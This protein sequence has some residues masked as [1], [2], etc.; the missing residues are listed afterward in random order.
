MEV[1]L[2]LASF[3]P[4]FDLDVPVLSDGSPRRYSFVLLHPSLLLLSLLLPPTTLEFLS[5][6]SR[7]LLKHGLCFAFAHQQASESIFLCRPPF[8]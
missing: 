7:I 2:G 6:I 5:S 3:P 8:E 4:P 1:L